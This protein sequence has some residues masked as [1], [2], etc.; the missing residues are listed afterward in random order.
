[1]RSQICTEV[2]E[3]TGTII[4]LLL[5]F[6]CLPPL[7]HIS[8]TFNL[9]FGLLFIGFHLVSSSINCIVARRLLSFRT[10]GYVIHQWEVRCQCR[11]KIWFLCSSE[12]TPLT[13]GNKFGDK[14]WNNGLIGNIR[15]RFGDWH[16]CFRWTVWVSPR[17]PTHLY[18]NSLWPF[19][20]PKRGGL[21]SNQSC[22]TQK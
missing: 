7:S 15:A 21:C 22:D 10:H 9:Q 4:T 2:N 12:A 3:N 17:Q 16:L 13:A 18:T 1:M 19:R 5:M 6:Y 8:F 11:L 14:T 20:M